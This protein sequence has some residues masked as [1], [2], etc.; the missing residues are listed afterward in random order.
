MILA[1]EVNG[2][3]IIVTCVVS[4]Y[5]RPIFE[6]RDSSNNVIISNM[7]RFTDNTYEMS[8]HVTIS[9]S[10]FNCQGAYFCHA[11]NTIQ[12]STLELVD[13]RDFCSEGE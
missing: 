2:N 10:R 8:V 3:Q 11:R 13:N 4:G 6:W 9:V 12:G 7:R 5:P 1:P